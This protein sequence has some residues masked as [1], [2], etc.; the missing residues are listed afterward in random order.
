MGFEVVV[1]NL[2]SDHD[3]QYRISIEP[4][5][6]LNPDNVEIV[7]R[8]LRDVYANKNVCVKIVRFSNPDEIVNWDAT[9]SSHGSDRD[10]RGKEVCIYLPVDKEAPNLLEIKES[11]L[12]VWACLQ[13]AKV[14]LMTFTPPGDKPILMDGYPTPFSYTFATQIDE[15]KKR[16]GILFKDCEK[17]IDCFDP[18]HPLHQVQFSFAEIKKYKL[19]FDKEMVKTKHVAY[20]VSHLSTTKKELSED[21]DH[22]IKESSPFAEINLDELFEEILDIK[23]K[24]DKKMDA[25]NDSNEEADTKIDKR[26]EAQNEAFDAFDKIKNMSIFLKAFP[27]AADSDF[28]SFAEL[29]LLNNHRILNL[30]ASAI[31][32]IKENLEAKWKKELALIQ[33]D[34]ETISVHKSLRKLYNKIIEN[35][36]PLKE[37]NP[38]ELQKIFRRFVFLNR[39]ATYLKRETKGIRPLE[40]NNICQRAINS[41]LVTRPKTLGFFSYYF[42]YA[43]G[44]KR[45]ATFSNLFQQYSQDQQV[46]DLLI[47]SLLAS[48]NG[49][50]LK[51]SIVSSLGY[52]SIKEAREHYQQQ[53]RDL[54]KEKEDNEGTKLLTILNEQIIAPI[55][56]ATDSHK[57]FDNP[58]IKLALE[59]YQT[60]ILADEPQSNNTIG[61]YK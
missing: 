44:L 56:K 48:E 8:I 53:F 46:L 41:Y 31:V 54:Y 21:V 45:A 49:K 6:L 35:L 55:V 10:Q 36:E 39:E 11:M 23:K 52:Q 25:I 5:Y 2:Q 60:K 24:Y 14:P 30:E 13:E 9:R 58:S 61:M 50:E 3:K 51:E 27:H 38:C 40:D 16:H 7:K 33:E 18:E 34:F 43:R 20:L 4:T 57:S 19:D 42:D 26:R 29:E 59:T 17:G 32:E 22:L 28:S 1:E 15:W 12:E 47:Y 37:K